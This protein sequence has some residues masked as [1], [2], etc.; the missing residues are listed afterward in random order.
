VRVIGTKDGAREPVPGYHFVDCP[1]SYPHEIGSLDSI[2]GEQVFLRTYTYESHEE[3]RDDFSDTLVGPRGKV[4]WNRLVVARSDV[5][6]LWPFG[7]E[8]PV[9]SGLPGRPTS[10]HLILGEFRR[11]VA[12]REFCRKLIDEA[13][14][15][16]GWLATHH[17]DNPP[18]GNKA[19][20]NMISAEH[21]AAK[22]I[23]S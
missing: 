20:Q 16:K 18:A 11:R 2:L 8:P 14:Y 7:L 10:A 9:K 21:R 22:A 17:S 15:L 5:L 19:I 13:E 23:K 4:L 1:I 3:W 6:D 12:L